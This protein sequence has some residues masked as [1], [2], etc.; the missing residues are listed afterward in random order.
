MRY[1]KVKTLSPAPVYD[2]TYPDMHIRMSFWQPAKQPID[3]MRAA[4]LVRLAYAGAIYR[5]RY[6]VPG[7]DDYQKEIAFKKQF[8]P[9]DHTGFVEHPS[10][11]KK[12]TVEM[13]S[14]R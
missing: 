12:P 10:V 4:S 2:A 11:G 3:V 14:L 1:R 5:Q 8:V 7:P 6:G 9:P 13:L